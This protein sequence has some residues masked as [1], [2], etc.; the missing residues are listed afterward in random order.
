[1]TFLCLPPRSPHV[2]TAQGLPSPRWCPP[3]TLGDHIHPWPWVYR[4]SAGCCSLP[5][6]HKEALADF[7]CGSHYGE[8]Q[9]FISSGKMQRMKAVEGREGD[10]APRVTPLAPDGQCSAP[11]HQHQQESNQ[12]LG[13]ELTEPALA[14]RLGASCQQEFWPRLMA[15]CG[16]SHKIFGNFNS[17]RGDDHLYRQSHGG[18]AGECM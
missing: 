11:L 2:A 3:C 10:T 13:W 9:P 4:P 18:G 17:Q 12:G 15:P 8:I 5:R 16:S 14:Q 7:I 1:M 6:H